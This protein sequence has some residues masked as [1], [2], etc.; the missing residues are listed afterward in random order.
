MR[1]LI[2]GFIFT[3][4]SFASKVG[5]WAWKRSV[6][7]A[8]ATGSVISMRYFLMILDS[9]VDQVATAPCTDCV[10]TRCATFEAKLYRLRKR[11]TL[12]FPKAR[13]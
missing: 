1:S 5:L 8:V 4:R 2:Q 11:S 10:Q 3:R 9:A 13:L 7:G 12:N 6:Q